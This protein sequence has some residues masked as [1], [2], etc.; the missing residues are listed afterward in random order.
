MNLV[1]YRAL[2][3]IPS[4]LP[5]SAALQDTNLLYEICP[6]GRLPATSGTTAL[7]VVYTSSGTAAQR[8]LRCLYPSFG[9]SSWLWG[10]G[11]DPGAALPLLRVITKRDFEATSVLSFHSAP[12]L[13]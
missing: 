12:V 8:P 10:L 5:I 13:L 3:F 11:D 1:V 2:V 7:A 4:P 9:H 6:Y